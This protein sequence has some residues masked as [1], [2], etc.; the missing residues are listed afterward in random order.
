ME[1]QAVQAVTQEAVKK[2]FGRKKYIASR[3]PLKYPQHLER[4]YIRITNG[5]MKLLNGTLAEYMPEIKGAL[6]EQGEAVADNT[7]SDASDWTG[8]SRM[9]RQVMER[10]E[11]DLLK[12]TANFDLVRKLNDL[13]NRARKYSIRE[14]KRVVGQTLGI[15]IFDDYYKSEFFRAN[16]RQWAQLN[17]DLI[18]SMPV[19]TLKCMT[20]IMQRGFYSGSSLKTLT[21]KVM[22]LNP[23]DFGLKPEMSLEAYKEAMAEYQK[24][25]RHAQF[26]ARDQMAKLNA[27]ITQQ[28]QSDAGVTEYVW[29][30][31]G[32]GRVRESHRHLNNKR[33]KYSD[34]PVVDNKTGRRANPGED[35][36]CRCVALPVFDID[37]VVL[38]WEQAA[39]GGD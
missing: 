35:Y 2:K 24:A 20:N 16:T 39:K 31:V 5:Y 6:L 26:I 14:W 33:F 36:Q 34:P 4:D 11:A 12:K 9:I 7:R 19:E 10:A 17:V 15:N 38:P 23:S 27:N 22:A 13:E 28:Q 18:K 25:K 32:D 1:M 30:T 37:T 3:S 29:R 8:F 21:G